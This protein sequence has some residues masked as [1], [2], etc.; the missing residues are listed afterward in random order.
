MIQIGTHQIN[1]NDPLVL[2]ALGGAALVVLLLILVL[3]SAGRSA[4]ALDPLAGHMT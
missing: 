2:A 1:L 4:Q 3:R